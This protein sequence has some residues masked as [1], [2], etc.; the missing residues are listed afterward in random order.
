MKLRGKVVM[1]PQLSGD[2]CKFRIFYNGVSYDVVSKGHQAVKDNIFVEQG[3]QIEMDGEIVENVFYTNRNKI[4]IRGECH[5]DI[6]RVQTL[7]EQARCI[8]IM[9]ENDLV[10]ASS[11]SVSYNVVTVVHR[12]LNEIQSEVQ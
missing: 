3:Q 10:S 4:N 2:V 6:E 11:D 8:V 12:L 1:K 7:V 9:L 5:M